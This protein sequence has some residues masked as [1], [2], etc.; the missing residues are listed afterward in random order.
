MNITRF[1]INGPLL[2]EPKIFSDSRGFFTERYKLQFSKELNLPEFIQDN[3]SR[4][5]PNVLRGLHYQWDQPQGKLVTA[6][7]G[8]IFDVAV[9][10]RKNSPTFG[11]HIHA[12]LDGNLAQWLW[13]PAG[14][15]HGFYVLGDEPADVMYKVDASYN[16]KGEAGILYNDPDLKI[17]WPTIE[18]ILSPKDKELISFNQYRENPKFFI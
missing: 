6:L 8:K 5:F 7:R 18:P 12:V 17:Q 16:P 9:D 13:I 1:A 11:Q 15:A 4:S 14:F 2:I 10:I 3:F